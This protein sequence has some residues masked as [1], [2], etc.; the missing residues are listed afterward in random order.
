M[1]AIPVP[2]YAP[3]QGLLT[4]TTSRLVNN[5][6]QDNNVASFSPCRQLVA[7]TDALTARCQ[8][9]ASMRGSLGTVRTFAGDATKQYR[10][11]GTAWTDVSRL[12]G[13]AYTIS[14]EHFWQYARFAELAIAVNKNDAPQKFTIETATNFEA[15]GGSPP[16]GK[17]V[18]VWGKFLVLLNLDTANFRMQWSALGDA[19]GW[20]IGVGLSDEQDFPEGGE[21]MGASYGRIQAVF[22]ENA[23]HRA[24]FVGPGDIFQFKEISSER[25]CAAAGSIAQYQDR[26][27]F[28]ARD[29][30]FMLTEAG[31]QP[32]GAQRVDT[33]FWADVNKS[34]LFRIVAT[35]DPFFKLYRISYPSINSAD[36]TCDKQL[37]YNW[38]IDRWTPADYTL[39]YLRRTITNTG[40]TL[41]DLDAIYPGGLETIPISLDSAAFSS[42]P[43]ESLAAFDTTHKLGFF[44]GTPLA[45]TIP[46]PETQLFPG[47]KAKVKAV[48]PIIEG[49]DSI[50]SGVKTKI[51]VR[52]NKLNDT[53]RFTAQVA[54]RDRGHSPFAAKRTKGRYHMPQTDIDAGVTWQNFQGWDIDAMQAGKR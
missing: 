6:V 15:L 50:G 32:I 35:C 3:D 47:W 1:P 4:P 41:E 52:D 11:N 37:I 8:G 53:Q 42:T 40:L 33:T 54:Q 22:L 9:A 13:G 5:V 24:T 34:Y 2:Q 39:E 29:G 45:A 25:G 49:L 44:D 30:F 27:F 20:T 10:Q 19:E 43:E 28:L 26:I 7:V 48:R 16:R 46:A 38:E 18:T 12:V 31:F 21:I 51:G 17:F 23:I 14:D 36:G